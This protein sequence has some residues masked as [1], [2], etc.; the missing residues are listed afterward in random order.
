ML[1]EVSTITGGDFEE[2]TYIFPVEDGLVVVDPGADVQVLQNHIMRAGKKVKYV[3][4]THGHIDHIFSLPYLSGA[5]VYAHEKEKTLLESPGLN[6][7]AMTGNR[8][9][10]PAITYVP[11]KVHTAGDFVFYHTPGHTSGSIVVKYG[12]ILF[13]GD[14]LFMDTIGRCD[15][16]TGDPQKMRE[17]LHIFS[18]FNKDT[19]CYP[20]HGDMFTLDKAFKVNNFLKK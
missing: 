13:T 18:Q 4:L 19:I 5:V 6:L 16:P 9:E 2:N 17:S 14:T 7:S 20:G 10:I 3:I 8:I 1:P 15:L 11:G 12:K